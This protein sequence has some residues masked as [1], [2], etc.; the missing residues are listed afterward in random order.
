MK[1]LFSWAL[2]KGPRGLQ[3]EVRQVPLRAPTAEVLAHGVSLDRAVIAMS[4][5]FEQ[6]CRRALLGQI[7]TPAIVF[8]CLVFEGAR[9]WLLNGSFAR[10]LFCQPEEVKGWQ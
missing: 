1:D 9:S 5:N 7:P 2:A 8:G 6:L 3:D 10:A 4:G